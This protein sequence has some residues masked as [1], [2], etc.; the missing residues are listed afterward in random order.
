MY[1]TAVSGLIVHVG[2]INLKKFQA[3][4]S[5]NSLTIPQ[6]AS[7]TPVCSPWYT[8]TFTAICWQLFGSELDNSHDVCW[9]ADKCLC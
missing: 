3:Q 9:P 6:S 8:S 5:S 7:R 1:V 4:L 2:Y